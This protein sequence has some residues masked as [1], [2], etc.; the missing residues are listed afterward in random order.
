M[1]PQSTLIICITSSAHSQ[2][3]HQEFVEDTAEDVI[4]FDHDGMTEPYYGH[5]LDTV[6]FPDL[7]GGLLH[8]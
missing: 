1:P 5:E 8:V 2:L 7:L 4:I 3:E 6:N